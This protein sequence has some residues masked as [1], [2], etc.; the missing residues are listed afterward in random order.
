MTDDIK[1]KTKNNK[2]NVN[3]LFKWNIVYLKCPVCA[4]S[5]IRKKN[6]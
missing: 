1:N 3:N 2:K 4:L 6:A 5:L